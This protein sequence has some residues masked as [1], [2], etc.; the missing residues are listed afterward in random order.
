[1]EALQLPTC[2]YR[3]N[4]VIEGK[5]PAGEV[6]KG[7]GTTLLADDE[8]MITDAGEQLLLTSDHKP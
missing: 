8:E 7:E 5:K 2:P 4:E 3:K 6:I 1:V